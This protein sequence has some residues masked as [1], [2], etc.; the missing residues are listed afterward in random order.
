MLRIPESPLSRFM[1]AELPDI[2]AVRNSYRAKMPSGWEPTAVRPSLQVT[3][4]PAWGMLGTAIDYRLQFAIGHPDLHSGALFGGVL[5]CQEVAADA[6]GLMQLMDGS[7]RRRSWLDDNGDEAFPPPDLRY[8]VGLEL[9]EHLDGLIRLHR[10]YDRGHSILLDSGTEQDFDRDVY[11][12]AWYNTVYRSRLVSLPGSPLEHPDG[13]TLS[14]LLMAVPSYALEDIAAM[15]KLAERGLD[16]LRRHSKPEEVALAPVFSAS[17]LVGGADADMI[18]GGLLLDVKAD[19]KAYDIVERQ[20]AHQL[21]GY[22][23][24]DTKNH[25]GIN[26]VGWYAARIGSLA[27]WELDEFFG[28]LGAHRT[29]KELREVMAK[30]LRAARVRRSSASFEEESD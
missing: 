16:S 17:G 10:P 25:Y 26:Q 1:T 6:A 8:N 14:S 24:L 18:V 20:T 4:K 3:V 11:A 27:T 7:A 9:I 28:L 12:A 21:A 19:A 23:L 5:R 13:M 15:V 2:S 22:A 29:V 30:N